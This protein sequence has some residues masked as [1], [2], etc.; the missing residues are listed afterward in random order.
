MVT[1]FY[2]SL[3]F[4]F[5]C[6]LWYMVDK[7]FFCCAYTCYYHFY[8]SDI[9]TMFTS[10]KVGC[11]HHV[12]SFNVVLLAQCLKLQYCPA[13]IMFQASVL[14]CRHHVC[15]YKRGSL[16]KSAQNLLF[17]ILVNRA[18]AF[19][20]PPWKEYKLF[21]IHAIGLFGFPRWSSQK[22]DAA[23]IIRKLSS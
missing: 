12:W 18:R 23:E 1:E 4:K 19:T 3:S 5:Y 22:K 15:N 11:W 7:W 6:K 21:W 14:F 17:K 2:W 16:Q 8:M 10:L 13:G 9:T 20:V